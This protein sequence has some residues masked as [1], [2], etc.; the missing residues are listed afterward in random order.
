MD[1]KILFSAM[2]NEGPF[3][4]EWVAY[5]LSIGF[6]KIVICSNDS[7]DGTTEL[8]DSL[9]DQGYV[10]HIPHTVAVG[11]SAQASAAQ[12]FNNSGIL[13][14]G[15]WALWLDADEFL[16]VHVGN[17]TV[18]ALIDR[19][20]ESQGAL[21]P[22]RIFGDSG[23]L[24]FSGRCI[25]PS[26]DR[27]AAWRSKSNRQ[28]KTMFKASQ[29]IL[30]LSGTGIHRP[31]LRSDSTL[32]L[33]DFLNGKGKGLH[34]KNRRHA[35]WLSGVNNGKNCKI[36]RS[37]FGWSLAQ[38]NHYCVRTPEYFALKKSRG[39]GYLSYNSGQTNTRHTRAFYEAFNRN[40]EEDRSILHWSDALDAKITEIKKSKLI[41]ENHTSCLKRS[42]EALD[43]IRE[44]IATIEDASM[45]MP[46]VTLPEA[47]KLFLT[48][49]YA[50]AKV[51]LEYGS[52]G[53]T[54]LAT[55]MGGKKVFSVESDFDW[56]NN[57]RSALNI[58]FPDCTSTHIHHVD[59][60]TTKEWGYPDGDSKWQNFHKYPLD[61]WDQHFFEHPDLILI[62]GRFRLA[63]FGAALLRITQPTTIL[64][65]DYVDRPEYHVAEKYC[66]V[67]EK[68]GRMVK[69][70]V[71]PTNWPQEHLTELISWFSIVR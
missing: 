61:I 13:N 45:S 53:S 22:W 39:R 37:D 51:I 20:G 57:M 63:C 30:G 11:N 44:W 47:E 59:I 49:Q 69:F 50:H 55:R 15:D 71:K 31:A 38:I 46:V 64:F 1:K 2:K 25:S 16:N 17:R 10:T 43:K 35:E 12:A 18:G 5:H 54:A 68:A 33:M 7:E 27:A 56:A 67:S 14:D 8:L 60:G 4:I 52:G 48:E 40:E 62:D 32:G 58:K 3:I 19:L 28:I 21:I 42:A 9:E 34:E 36:N 26:F 70:E 65:D 41:A 6:D 24:K 23:N 29:N 66:T